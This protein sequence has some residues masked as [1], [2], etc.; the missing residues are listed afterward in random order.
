MKDKKGA[1]PLVRKPRPPKV[2]PR[3]VEP[4]NECK[5]CL[6]KGV[7]YRDASPDPVEIQCGTCLGLGWDTPPGTP[8]DLSGPA[9]VKP[10]PFSGPGCATCMDTGVV[11]M[12]SKRPADGSLL[13]ETQPCPYG[14]AKPTPIKPRLTPAIYETSCGRCEGSGIM[15]TSSGDARC[16]RCQGRGRF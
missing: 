10:V 8:V 9:L 14:C 1:V 2:I 7:L 4:P 5:T 12:L 6:G 15:N 16:N 13:V 3:R 11:D